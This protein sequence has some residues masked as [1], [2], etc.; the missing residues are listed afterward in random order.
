MRHSIPYE[1]FRDTEKAKLVDMEKVWEII[2][3]MNFPIPEVLN[4]LYDKEGDPT[5]T[6][7]K[8]ASEKFSLSYTRAATC[9]EKAFRA[10]RQPYQEKKYMKTGI[11]E[12]ISL[13]DFTSEELLTELARRL[14][15]VR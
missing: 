15:D 7:I 3:S 6:T 8:K 11:R 5:E 14:K 10:L 12:N 9:E 4:L 13:K 1:I 2:N